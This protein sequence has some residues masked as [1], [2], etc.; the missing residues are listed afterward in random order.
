MKQKL[1]FVIFGG[2]NIYFFTYDDDRMNVT[3]AHCAENSI[4]FNHNWNSSLT[5]GRPHVSVTTV[6]IFQPQLALFASCVMAWACLLH[7][8]LF[9]AVK[10]SNEATFNDHTIACRC[11]ALVSRA[12]PK[13]HTHD[14]LMLY[15][16][17]M[18]TLL[19]DTMQL[20]VVALRSS[21]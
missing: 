7:Y 4:L 21:N 2:E 10:F 5:L 16:N 11:F 12:M 3:F 20:L 15:A 17:F 9:E 19:V 14:R 13:R 8:G 1:I 6:C 18:C